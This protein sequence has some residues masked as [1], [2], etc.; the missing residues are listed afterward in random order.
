M[1]TLDEF[2]AVF[3]ASPDG[4]LVVTSDGSIHAANR[5]VEQMFG[6]N[7][8]ELA[9][10]S[11]DRLLPN[12]VRRAHRRHREGFMKQP[13][14][15]AMGLGLELRAQRKDGT[16]FPVE[17]SLNPWQS[18]DGSPKVICSIRDVTE[19]RRMRDFTEGALRA[20]EEERSRISHELHD[21]TA[22]RLATLLLKLRVLAAEQDEVARI[23][24]CH[25]LREQIVATAD[26]VRRMAHGLRP[27]E[28]EQLGLSAALHA[29]ARG[30]TQHER[31]RLDL[32]IDPVDSFLDSTQQLALY[33]IIQEAT[34]NARQHSGASGAQLTIT[35]E[36][37]VLSVTVRDEGSGFDPES[38]PSLGDGLG[39]IGMRERAAMI[40]GGLTVES[41]P[42]SGTSITVRLSLPREDTR[43][44]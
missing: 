16:V 33:R 24:R 37:E 8:D 18:E 5:K 29:H 40:G 28:L 15:R 14:E 26:S 10:M 2:K 23:A 39:L 6:L 11:V 38:D 4:I 19:R 34:N 7:P 22:Q 27:P 30:L 35:L 42:G 43:D 21:D 13:R 1:L 41:T 3:D 25:D 20:S 9:G 17:V 31:F 32:R 12:A 44:V 36:E